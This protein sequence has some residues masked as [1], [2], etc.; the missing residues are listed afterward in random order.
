MEW[1]LVAVG[2]SEYYMIYQTEDIR[3]YLTKES[4]RATL[5][6]K[7]IKQVLPVYHIYDEPLANGLYA[8]PVSEIGM[9]SIVESKEQWVEVSVDAYSHDA[10]MLKDILKY[11]PQGG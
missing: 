8:I 6:F 2:I 5:Y 4:S 7:D 9:L 11:P 3:Q 1:L 10:T